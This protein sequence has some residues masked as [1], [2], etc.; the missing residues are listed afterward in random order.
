MGHEKWELTT[1]TEFSLS[2][3]KDKETVFDGEEEE[4][5]EEEEEK[6]DDG[7][8]CKAVK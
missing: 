2:K 8:D 4:L 1:L 6:F 3:D 7:G 5:E